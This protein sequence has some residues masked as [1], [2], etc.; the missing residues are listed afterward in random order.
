MPAR[1][2]KPRSKSSQRKP[3]RTSGIRVAGMDITNA[4]DV[5]GWGIGTSSPSK[6]KRK[7]R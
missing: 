1:K 2:P 7:K 3:R 5:G 6:S 4:F